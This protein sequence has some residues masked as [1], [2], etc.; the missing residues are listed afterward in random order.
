MRRKGSPWH[1]TR[2]VFP[3]ELF[4]HLT[5]ARIARAASSFVRAP[6]ARGGISC[7]SS[8]SSWLILLQKSVA[9]FCEQ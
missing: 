5:G 9:G 6:R 1:E 7:P 8:T 2:C 4:N 3:E